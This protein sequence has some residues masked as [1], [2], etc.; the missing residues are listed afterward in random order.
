MMVELTPVEIRQEKGQTL[1]RDFHSKHTSALRLEGDHIGGA[2]A[3]GF[4]LAEWL[5]QAGREQIRNNIGDG[6][7][8]ET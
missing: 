3:I 4:T 5:D 8:T 2:A 1:G 7:S 6:R